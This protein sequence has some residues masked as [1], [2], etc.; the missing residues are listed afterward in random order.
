MDRTITFIL[1][2]ID[3]NPNNQSLGE[4]VRCLKETIFFLCIETNE[5]LYEFLFAL[6][7]HNPNDAELGGKLRTIKKQIT[8]YFND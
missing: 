5:P 3:K 8:E 6:I 2:S 7:H 1:E 4:E